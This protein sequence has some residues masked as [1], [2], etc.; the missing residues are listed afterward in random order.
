[1]WPVTKKTPRDSTKKYSPR[2]LAYGDGAQMTPYHEKEPIS[3]QKGLD[4]VPS[5][6]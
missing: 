3:C 5:R 6:N 2:G 1:M 4:L